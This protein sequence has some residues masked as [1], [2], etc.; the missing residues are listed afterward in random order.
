[1]P[2]FS[3]TFE[4]VA[5]QLGDDASVMGAAAWARDSVAVAAPTEGETESDKKS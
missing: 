1:M 2:S 3:D 4:I 5:A